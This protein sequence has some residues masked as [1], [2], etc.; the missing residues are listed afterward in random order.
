LG[1]RRKGVG[2]RRNGVGERRKGVHL[3]WDNFP[4]IDLNDTNLCLHMHLTIVGMFNSMSYFFLNERSPW[5]YVS[6]ICNYLCNQCL[7]PVELWGL[8]PLMARCTRFKIM[9]MTFH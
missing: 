9:Q 3:Y 4:C 1:E 8:L 6:W 5:S 7:S 2:E